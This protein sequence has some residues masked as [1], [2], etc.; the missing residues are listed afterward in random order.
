MICEICK[1]EYQGR[2]KRFCSWEC[3]NYSLGSINRGKGK[4]VECST[5]GN[6]LWRKEYLISKSKNHFCDKKCFG[7]FK[8]NLDFSWATGKN[9]WNWQGGISFLGKALYKQIRKIKKYID[10]RKDIYSRDNFTC[11]HCGFIGGKLNVDHYPTP[12]SKIIVKNN[13]ETLEEA[14][15]CKELWDISNGRTLCEPCHK[16]IGF[17]GSHIININA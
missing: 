1:K 2:G 14:L 3:R 6:E 17:K 10:W 13:I 9:H 4:L 11:Q 7:E 12:F 15:E 8:S 16:E 5:C